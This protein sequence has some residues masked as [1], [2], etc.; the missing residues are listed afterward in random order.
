MNLCIFNCLV[1]PQSKF[2]TQWQRRY[3]RVR[4]G[5]ERKCSVIFPGLKWVKEGYKAKEIVGSGRSLGHTPRAQ[6]HCYR[7]I[8]TK[9]VF[10][11][12][13]WF[14]WDYFSSSW[15]FRTMPGLSAMGKVPPRGMRRGLSCILT[16]AGKFEPFSELPTSVS[17]PRMWK[18]VG[19]RRQDK[20]KIVP[21]R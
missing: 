13:V 2:Q 20:V 9:D 15:D 8:G 7:N 1:L 14:L 19:C 4:G 18:A 11:I 17:Y 12:S 10:T 5:N 21:R 3:M 6:G 16:Q